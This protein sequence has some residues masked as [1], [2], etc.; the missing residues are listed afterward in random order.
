MQEKRQGNKIRVGITHGDVNGISYEV[1]IKTFID[2]KIAE[3]FVPILYGSS[4]VASYHRKI[5]G[6]SDFS[7][8]I[9]KNADQVNPK[10]P[11]IINI[12]DHEIKI[13][14]GKM[15]EKAGELAYFA[16]E[17][18]TRD[19]KQGLIDVLVTGPV[20]KASIHSEKFNFPGHTEYLARTFESDNYLMMMV[21]DD[22]KIGILTG[23]VPL[24]EVSGLITKELLVKK[25]KV[26]NE[27]LIQD[28]NLTK[29]RIAVLSLNPH[30]GDM[31]LIGD[32]EKDIMIPVIEQAKNDKMLVFG[33]YAADGF[34]GSMNHTRFDG[35]LAM[36]HDQGMIPFKTLAFHE[37][38]NYTAGLPFVRTSPAHGTGFEIAGQ[39]IASPDSLRK[40]IYLAIDL[41]HNRLEYEEISKNP[42]QVSA[43]E[44]LNEK[45]DLT[46]D[47]NENSS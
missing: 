31:G 38:V 21:Q 43:A 1:I 13:E 25:I 10:R 18:A 46:V 4:K 32:E 16:L 7:F 34:F 3:D 44:E 22:L 39:N 40:A 24:K 41:Y 33:P 30:A 17:R 47:L 12:Y 8:N 11:N 2:Q 19:L 29:P 20:N 23:H 26:F 9:V 14:V 35:V 6:I 15:S 45:N 28:F 27:S 42:L 37:G 36:Y 5:L